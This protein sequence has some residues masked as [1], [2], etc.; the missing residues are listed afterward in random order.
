MK[1]DADRTFHS[2]I[3]KIDD[4]SIYYGLFGICSENNAGVSRRIGWADNLTP[5]GIIVRAW[6]PDPN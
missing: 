1:I 2:S 6:K 3:G 4:I 5:A